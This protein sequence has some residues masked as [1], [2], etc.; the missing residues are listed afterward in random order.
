MILMVE[1]KNQQVAMS[2]AK[3]TNLLVAPGLGLEYVSVSMASLAIGFTL[4]RLSVRSVNN[5]VGVSSI[6][7]K[8][9]CDR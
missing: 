7:N 2:A 9:R 3:A 6:E 1:R 8:M 4:I 5:L